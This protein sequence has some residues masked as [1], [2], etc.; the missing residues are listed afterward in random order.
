VLGVVILIPGL[1]FAFAPWSDC[2]IAVMGRYDRGSPPDLAATAFTACWNQAQ[3]RRLWA[4]LLVAIGILVLA[5]DF[6][7]RWS[8]SHRNA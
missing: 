5:I 7:V 8:R 3:G 2:G 4:A 6:L 1:Y